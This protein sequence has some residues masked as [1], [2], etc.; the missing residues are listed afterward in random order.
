MRLARELGLIPVFS[1]ASGAMISPGLFILPGLAHARAGPAIVLS[2]FPA[3]LPAMG[4]LLSIIESTTAMPKAGQLHHSLTPISG[5]AAAFM[6]SAGR[7]TVAAAV[8][9]AFLTTVNAGIMTASRY[10]FAISRDQL[11]PGL[12]GRIGT[13]SQTPWIDDHFVATSSSITK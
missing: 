7:F 12:F 10:L 4:G 1:L 5:A 13:R 3:G 11:L 8:L 9:P 6:G 2:Y